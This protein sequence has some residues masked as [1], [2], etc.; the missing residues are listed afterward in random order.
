[1]NAK[2]DLYEKN[3]SLNTI[4]QLNQIW[5]DVIFLKTSIVFAIFKICLERDVLK[6]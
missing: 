3:S 6:I 2:F 5:S 1:M 4:E